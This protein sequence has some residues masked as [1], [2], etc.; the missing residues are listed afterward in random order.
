[1]QINK[2]D[3]NNFNGI[4]AK[5]LIQNNYAKEKQYKY[6][7]EA[8]S[9]FGGMI[10][11]SPARLMELTRDASTK[12]FTFL[13]AMVNKYNYKNFDNVKEN[14]EHILNIYSMVEKPSAL[15]VNIVNKFEDSFESLEKIFSLAKD[16]KTLEYVENLQYGTLKDTN[17]PSKIIVDLLSSKN[18]EKYISKPESYASYLK[19][20]SDD[21]NAVNKLDELI[22]TGRYSK[23][24]S[25]AQLA[26]KR[27]MRKQNVKVAMAG[28]TSDLERMYTKDRENFLTSLIK[29]FIP[30]RKEPKEETK[31]MVVEM[32][33]TLNSENAKLRNA[34]IERF[35]GAPIKD[36]TA[37]IIEMQTL[38]NRI[39]KDNDAKSFVQKAISKDLKIASIEELNEILNIAP[40]KKANIF[41]NNAKRII[42]RS[43]GDERKT[44]LIVELENPFSESKQPRNQKARIVRM[45]ADKPQK[46]SIFTKTVKIIENKINQYRYSRLSA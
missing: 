15:H 31:S 7:Q 25:D 36:R 37:E 42:E 20:H 24:R 11:Q 21:E 23:M 40:L 14:S 4:G 29:A 30:A 44:A 17:N 41:F 8:C 27:I 43:S 39:D 6:M 45:F 19:L 32:Y 16:E 1:M 33:G 34:I 26:I 18:R 13:K 22:E 38:F 35:K 3:N 10:G 46:E 2:I 5:R 9:K 12:Q 28:K